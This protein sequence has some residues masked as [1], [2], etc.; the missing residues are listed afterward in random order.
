MST[1]SSKIKMLKDT[2]MVHFMCQLG[3]I[4][5]PRYGLRYQDIFDEINI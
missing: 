1:N 5:V 2:V 4:M 3:W